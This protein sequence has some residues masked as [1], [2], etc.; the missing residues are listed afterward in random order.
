ME[1]RRQGGLFGTTI[2]RE[3]VLGDRA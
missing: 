1:V 3:Y 2:F